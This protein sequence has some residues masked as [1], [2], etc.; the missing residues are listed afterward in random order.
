MNV[1]NTGY[2]IGDSGLKRCDFNVSSSNFP[3]PIP[4]FQSMSIAGLTA[5]IHIQSRS[6]V[7]R[8]Q[9]IGKKIQY[10]SSFDLCNIE[11]GDMGGNVTETRNTVVFIG[12]LMIN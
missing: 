9:G 7:L 5:G 10:H 12:S 3:H 11:A 1:Y 4:T 6:V 2:K 8:V